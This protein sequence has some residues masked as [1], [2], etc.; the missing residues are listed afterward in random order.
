MTD[1][2]FWVTSMFGT[3]T[4]EAIVNVAV[5]GGSLVQMRPHE[6]RDLA[7]NL[8]RCA[9]AAEADAFVWH[10]L[11]DKLPD[12]PDAAVAGVIGDFRKWREAHE[13]LP[14]PMDPPAPVRP[15]MRLTL[16]D[17]RRGPGLRC[18]R[19]GR[20]SYNENDIAM[21]YCPNCHLF[22]DLEESQP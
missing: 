16:P 13:P 18:L 17:G 19:C 7:L 9:E 2:T 1:K 11:H 8:L 12:L 5:P 6:A 14:E 22:G 10:F 21:K 3:R 20:T 15:R 4:K